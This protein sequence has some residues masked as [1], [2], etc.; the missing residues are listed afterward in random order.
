ML[1]AEGWIEPSTQLTAMR[2][3]GNRLLF[4]FIDSFDIQPFYLPEYCCSFTV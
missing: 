4:L 3:G 1:S 2:A